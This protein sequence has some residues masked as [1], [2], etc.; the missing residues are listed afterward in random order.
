MSQSGRTE[1]FIM[2]DGTIRRNERKKKPGTGLR[3]F[4]AREELMPFEHLGSNS[5]PSFISKDSIADPV[6]RNMC[7]GLVSQQQR[8]AFLSSISLC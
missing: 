6:V 8:W 1:R 7:C 3:M 5:V 4:S 2:T